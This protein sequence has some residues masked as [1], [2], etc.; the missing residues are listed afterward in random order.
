MAKWSGECSVELLVI[1][2]VALLGNERGHC[3]V[4]DWELARAAHWD[5]QMAGATAAM[6]ALSMVGRW[7]GRLASQSVGWKGNRTAASSAAWRECVS[8]VST[9][10][11]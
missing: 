8:V 9:G 5:V 1:A 11:Y 3:L 10:M 6:L 7:V 4:A 2:K